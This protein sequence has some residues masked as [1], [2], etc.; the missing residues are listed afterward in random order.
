M[1]S[2]TRIRQPSFQ[3]LS[4]VER[5]SFAQFFESIR[6]SNRFDYGAFR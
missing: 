2:E 5:A 3:S 4:V 1:R 6:L